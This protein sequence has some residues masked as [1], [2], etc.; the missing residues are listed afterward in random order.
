MKIGKQ[1]PLL[2]LIATFALAG[3]GDGDDAPPPPPPADQGQAAPM[4]GQDMDPEMMA[5]MQEAQQ[6]Q[7]RLGP[8]QQQALQDE[9]LAG[10]RMDLQERVESAMREENAELIDR[11]EDLETEFMAAQQAGDQERLQQIGME[12][13]GLD[14]ELQA[15]Q[16]SVFERPDIQ[17]PLEA[18]E[19][20]QRARM[21]ELDPEAADL[22]D[23][24]DEI[25]DQLNL[26]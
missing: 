14:M 11:M 1:V 5:L 15:L 4:P 16:Q 26:R 21:L 17:E 3:C 2:A 23:R 22:L 8:L 24:M 25:L 10:Q 18:F 9:E 12:A 19:E 13:Q 20:A 6:L 7:E